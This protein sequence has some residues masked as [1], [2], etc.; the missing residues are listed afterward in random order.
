MK[1]YCYLRV[2]TEQQE[3]KSQKVGI[4]KFIK[5]K[6][7]KQVTWVTDT[8][9]GSSKWSERRLGLIWQEAAQGDLLIVSELSRIGRSTVDVL[10]FLQE[11][12]KTGLSV[13]AVKN[14]ITL[15]GSITST[16]FATVM[17]LAA[18]IERDFIR[19]RTKEGMERAK[20][21]GVKIGRP[22][23][24]KGVKKLDTVRDEVIK[25]A[26]AGVSNTAI[27]TLCKVS[28]G[29]VGRYLKTTN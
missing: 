29:T 8:I 10:Q 19:S 11:A 24:S 1:I 22:P 17:G 2:S 21:A 20:A 16:I 4:E 25:L 15:D 28:R 9:S 5:D 14:N 6:D 27:A 3:L 18:E 26:K 13:H 23:G 7:Y 12:A